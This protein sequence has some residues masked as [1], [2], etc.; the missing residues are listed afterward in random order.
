M[1][2]ACAGVPGAREPDHVVRAVIGR[3]LRGGGET[4]F[5]GQVSPPPIE[6]ALTA[7]GARPHGP[8]PRGHPL[9]GP[10]QRDLRRD[11]GPGHL[12][13]RDRAQGRGRDVRGAGDPRQG[14]AQVAARREVPAPE[15]APGEALVA[16]MASAIN[17]NT[18]WTSIFEPVLDVRLPR[19]LRPHR[20]SSPSATT[21]PTTWSAPT[22]PASCCAPAPASPSGSRAPRSSRTASRVELEDAE[23]HNDTMLDP[24]QRI[25]GFETNFG[26]LAELAI[27]KANQLM[28]KPG[29]P[30]LG[31]GG[32]PRAGQQHGLPAADLPERRRA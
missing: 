4:R 25:W 30:D 9:R 15:L 29:P 6:H 8:D 22:S 14:P 13:R 17:Y 10:Q 2:R 12:P 3:R 23:G 19:A 5:A 20:R 26:G 32:L 28:P 21:C 1:P 16:V 11:R 31:G 24:Q 7:E 18:V 27:V